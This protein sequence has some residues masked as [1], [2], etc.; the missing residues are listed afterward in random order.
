MNQIRIAGV[1][2]AG[3]LLEIYSPYILESAISFEM[4]APSVT[5]FRARIADTLKKFPWLVC[6]SAGQ[7]VGYAYAGTFRTRAAYN[8]TAE[9]T[10]YVRKNHHGKGV[11]SDLY[12]TLLDILK[13]QGVVNV[14]GGITLP[15]SGSERLHE[16]FG[17]QKVAHVKDAG[18][19]LGRW[20]DVGYWQLQFEKPMTPEPLRKFSDL[21]K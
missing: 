20:W 9:A 12:K 4:E 16:K 3:K 1:E 13:R 14:I 2:D 17:F 5:E 8:W 15:N 19:K 11:G 6:E 18:F 21:T 10:V 7:A